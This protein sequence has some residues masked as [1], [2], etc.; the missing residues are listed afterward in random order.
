MLGC[1]TNDL[2]VMRVQIY[3]FY[4]STSG[5]YRSQLRADKVNVLIKVGRAPP[6]KSQRNFVLDSNHELSG[7]L[8]AKLPM[9][10]SFIG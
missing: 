3:G 1:V 9:S 10:S 5:V 2:N 7:L 4:D 8:L 6:S